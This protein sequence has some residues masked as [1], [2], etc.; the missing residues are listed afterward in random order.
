MNNTFTKLM[1][2]LVDEWPIA[3]TIGLPTFGL[4]AGLV[5]GQTTSPAAPI[6][7]SWPAM[8]LGIVLIVIAI[9][10]LVA[11][12]I[13]IAINKREPSVQPDAT[14]TPTNDED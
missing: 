11:T 6:T 1:A 14:R 2:L 5:G 7:P 9:A 4:G 8:A 3:V 12:M 10:V 13:A